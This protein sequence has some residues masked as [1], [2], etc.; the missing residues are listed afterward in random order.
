MESTIVFIDGAYLAKVSKHFGNG[1]YLKI[2][3]NQFAMT[4]AKDS[5]FQC[6][7]VFFYDAPP[8]Q[9]P[10]PTPDQNRRKAGY[11]K[12]INKLRKA[13]NF[14]VREGRC[15]KIDNKY[16]QKGVDTLITMD[17]MEV[18]NDIKTIILF[19][20]D[21]DFVPVIKEI[22]NRKKINVILYYYSDRKRNSNFSMSNH[23]INV[24]DISKLITKD[25]FDRSLLK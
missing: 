18:P 4:L 11:D 12:L 23:I 20:S 10:N 25:F 22:R 5:N 9:D 19:T 21:T 6:S 15:Q 24:C 3:Y 13:P 17:L 2:D 14:I 1:K 8:Y 16:K 7:K